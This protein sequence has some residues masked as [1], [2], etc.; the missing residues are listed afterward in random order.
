VLA[1]LAA[2][3]HVLARRKG[4]FHLE[5]F[6]VGA[7]TG[8]SI[9]TGHVRANVCPQQIVVI[10]RIRFRLLTLALLRFTWCALAHMFGARLEGY[11]TGRSVG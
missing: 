10:I 3:A 2:L 4:A 6:A 1:C 7:C 8:E 11:R 5:T 9:G